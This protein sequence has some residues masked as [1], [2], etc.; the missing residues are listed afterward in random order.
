MK[1]ADLAAQAKREPWTLDDDQGQ[2][3][4]TIPQPDVSTWVKLGDAETMTDVLKLLAGSEYEPLMAH[5]APLGAPALEQAAGDMR[6]AF[7]LGN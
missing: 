1:L 5:L 2:P 4:V 3:L 7:G 6:K